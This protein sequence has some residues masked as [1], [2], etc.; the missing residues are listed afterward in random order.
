MSESVR[1]RRVSERVRKWGRVEGGRGRE[2]VD[3]W[4]SSAGSATASYC[5]AKEGVQETHTLLS[6]TNQL[7]PGASPAVW[8]GCLDVWTWCVFTWRH[9]EQLALQDLFSNLWQC[10]SGDFQ[11]WDNPGPG[12]LRNTLYSDSLAENCWACTHRFTCS[13]MLS[14]C[15]F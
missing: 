5:Q 7:F 12:F 11:Q 10:K 14:T 13:I 2:L 6:G 8:A 9:L 3:K 4:E 15:C 1:W